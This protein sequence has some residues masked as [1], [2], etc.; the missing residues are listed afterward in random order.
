MSRLSISTSL[1]HSLSPAIAILASRVREFTGR[2]TPL[3]ASCSSVPASTSIPPEI[4]DYIKTALKDVLWPMM[5][6]R[7]YAL[8][9]LIVHNL[10]S[11]SAEL[12]TA[13]SNRYNEPELTLQENLHGG[14]CW[15]L[16]DRGQLGIV[17]SGV[18]HPTHVTIDHI[19]AELLLEPEQAPRRLILWGVIDGEHNVAQYSSH[20]EDFE[21]VAQVDRRAPPIH[22]G[23]S[24]APLL[25]FEYDIHMWL[26]SQTF[27]LHPAVD[28]TRL[29]VGIY[30]LEIVT[31]WGADLTCLYRVRIHGEEFL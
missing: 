13:S 23:Y 4:S 11:H 9:A 3:P 22:A 15:I 24:F 21:A 26:P 7:D 27:A 16:S 31:N 28:G 6:R 19:P 20:Q 5:G 1:Q 25:D 30:V 14:Q 2:G 10:T 18:I 17:I 8:G 29:R 12:P